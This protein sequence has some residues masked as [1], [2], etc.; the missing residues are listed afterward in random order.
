MKRGTHLS[1]HCVQHVFNPCKPLSLRR[2]QSRDVTRRVRRHFF[3]QEE[4]TEETPL[5]RSLSHKE[6][7]TRNETVLIYEQLRQVAIFDEW[8]LNMAAWLLKSV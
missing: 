7:A 6:R 3:E 1:E 2:H 8:R 4:R 5:A